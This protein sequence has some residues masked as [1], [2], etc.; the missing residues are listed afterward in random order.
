M[1]FQ[2]FFFQWRKIER[3]CIEHHIR[4]FCIHF[5]NCIILLWNKINWFRQ[6]KIIYFRMEMRN[7]TGRVAMKTGISPTGTWQLDNLLLGL[8]PVLPS[9]RE[10]IGDGQ[11]RLQANKKIVKN[12]FLI[13]F[14]ILLHAST[15]R[16][17]FSKKLNSNQSK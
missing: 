4:V 12:G 10:R 2:T 15:L 13:N 3:T 5:I 6:K 17:I 14:Y 7:G 16:S 1:V 9:P 8:M 11:E